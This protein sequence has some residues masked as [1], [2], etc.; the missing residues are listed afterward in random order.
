MK[1]LLS[2]LF[3]TIMTFG[4][5]SCNKDDETKEKKIEENQCIY[6]ETAYVISA[7]SLDTGSVSQSINIEVNFGVNNGCGHF[8]R[9]IET[10]SGN[11][12]TIEVE[13]KYDGCICTLDAPI[14]TVNYGFIPTQTGNYEL[15]FKSSP[16]E[17]I[18][19]YIT[20]N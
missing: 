20:V 16:T 3:F 12:R 18:T 5:S 17:F 2:I 11:T 9:F 6:S 14:R 7:N 19:I 15:K 1:N 4:L 10:Q 13:A 8:G